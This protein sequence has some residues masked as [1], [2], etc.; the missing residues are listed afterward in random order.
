MVPWQASRQVPVH[1]PFA[2]PVGRCYT[3]GS[4][5]YPKHHEIRAAAW[6]VVWQV[7]G[8][9]VSVAGTP[10]GKQTAANA[11]LAALVMAVQHRVGDLEV[12]TDCKGVASGA[13][14]VLRKGAVP[15][16]LASTP[17]APMWAKLAEAS[18][19]PG[20]VTV[21]WMRAHTVCAAQAG[22]ASCTA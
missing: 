9:W 6:S 1:G 15:R 18:R 11:E 5:V 17:L 19:G 4:C 16:W 12:V 8:E 7:G 10:A 20:K 3:D 22:T 21:R 13:R 2:V 14:A